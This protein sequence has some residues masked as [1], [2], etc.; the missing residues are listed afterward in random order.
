MA[1]AENVPDDFPVR[2]RHREKGIRLA[3]KFGKSAF[4]RRL[5]HDK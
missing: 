3:H 1:E 2:L 5:L 4:K